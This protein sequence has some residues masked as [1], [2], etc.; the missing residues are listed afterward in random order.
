M[1]L[2][3]RSKYCNRFDETWTI[4]EG[5][6]LCPLFIGCLL[7]YVFQ[8]VRSYHAKSRIKQFSGAVIDERPPKRQRLAGNDLC[9]LEDEINGIKESIEDIATQVRHQRRNMSEVLRE[10]RQWKSAVV[11]FIFITP[12]LLLI[13]FFSSGPFLRYAYRCGQIISCISSVPN[14]I[15]FLFVVRFCKTQTISYVT[16]WL[17]N[18]PAHYLESCMISCF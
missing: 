8:R 15:S 13:S 14:I 5:R 9:W 2:P 3:A 18:K 12:M 6:L 1:H 7:L 10:V 4:S 17:S 16:A 11:H